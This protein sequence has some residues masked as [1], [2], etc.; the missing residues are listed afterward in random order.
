V[1]SG[2]P[3]TPWRDRGVVVVGSSVAGIG[4]FVFVLLATRSLGLDG[5]H[6]ISQLWTVWAIAVAVVTFST[7]VVTVRRE[8]TVVASS[9]S[10]V[11]EFVPLI[12]LLAVVV[13]TLFL[14]RERIFDDTSFFW[15]V[16]GSL[17]P[18][19]SFATGRARGWLAV[20][21]SAP[22]LAA[23][24]GGENAVRCVI[25]V[26]LAILGAGAGWYALAILAGYS[27]AFIGLG[28]IRSVRPRDR[29]HTAPSDGLLPTAASIAGICDHIL[30]VAAPTVLAASSGDSVVVSAMF[31][32]M[33]VYRAPYQ[34]A[35]GLVPSLTRSFVER[36]PHWQPG[37]RRR[38]TIQTLGWAMLATAVAGVVAAGLGESLIAPIF[39]SQGILDAVDHGLA[40]ALTVVATGALVASVALLVL[41]RSKLI[42]SVWLTVTVATVTVAFLVDDDP[43]SILIV[44]L[45]G[46]VV[47]T[48]ALVPALLT[49]Q[50]HG[51]FH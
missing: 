35:L 44:M 36:M 7:Q 51:R 34:F 45:A 12:F 21:G 39:A 42:M 46:S 49:P 8:A 25:G 32:A 29:S 20:H 4:A 31:V 14:F 15:P 17:I 19:G 5:F 50:A 27:V 28:R 37:E 10:R 33:A 26:I 30:L 40:G 47:A 11:A 16:A 2:P 13:P 22:Q 1:T 6:P 38:L 3:T 23:V 41:N 9:S 48:S 24:I 43:T 18:I